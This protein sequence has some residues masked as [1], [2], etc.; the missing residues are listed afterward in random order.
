[1]AKR[2]PCSDRLRRHALHRRRNILVATLAFNHDELGAFWSGKHEY[3][4]RRRKGEN[5]PQISLDRAAFPSGESR[6][7]A[8]YSICWGP[9][10]DALLYMGV[11][12]ISVRAAAFGK[13]SVLAPR[14]LRPSAG[15]RIKSLHLVGMY[16]RSL[17]KSLLV[18]QIYR[19]TDTQKLKISRDIQGN[20]WPPQITTNSHSPIS[21]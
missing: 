17:S 19:H 8:K 10:I 1:M 18:T 15:V 3:Q 5:N 12:Y 14:D 11:P 21:R 9:T 6:L 7:N 13:N 20:T 2:T 16:V 4:C